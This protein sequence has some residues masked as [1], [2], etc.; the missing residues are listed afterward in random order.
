MSGNGMR[1]SPRQ[2]REY[3]KRRRK[4]GNSEAVAGTEDRGR[5]KNALQ[6]I[7]EQFAAKNGGIAYNAGEESLVTA[8]QRFAAGIPFPFARQVRIRPNRGFTLDFAIL[9]I[10]LAIEVDGG[11]HG[12]Y[13]HEGA[14]YLNR[15]KMEADREKWNLCAEDGICLLHYMDSQIADKPDEVIKQVLEIWQKRKEIK[16]A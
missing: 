8:W 7:G 15:E 11:C 1:W 5:G 14:Q 12:T 2:A 13:L 4:D 9:S 16:Q 3:V 10:G 6:T